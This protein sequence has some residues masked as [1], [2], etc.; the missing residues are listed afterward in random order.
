MMRAA[1]AHPRAQGPTQSPPQPPGVH[2]GIDCALKHRPQRHGAPSS[3]CR[4]SPYRAGGGGLVGGHC[5]AIGRSGIVKVARRIAMSKNH[6]QVLV[7]DPPLALFAGRF[8]SECRKGAAGIAER[9][10]EVRRFLGVVLGDHDPAYISHLTIFPNLHRLG[11]NTGGQTGRSRS[12]SLSFCVW[13]GSIYLTHVH[14]Q[15]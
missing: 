6:P 8:P 5:G 9:A 2:R 10:P 11:H 13:F 14:R 7:P 3:Q 1:G 12:I 15:P 4:A